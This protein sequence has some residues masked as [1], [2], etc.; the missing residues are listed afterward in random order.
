MRR[1]LFNSVAGASLMAF[2]LMATAQD[3]FHHTTATLIST[4]NIGTGACLNR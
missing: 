3:P 4:E 1:F 2:S